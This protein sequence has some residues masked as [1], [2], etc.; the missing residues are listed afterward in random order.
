MGTAHQTSRTVTIRFI[1]PSINQTNRYSLPTVPLSSTVAELRTRLV[2][3]FPDLPFSPA[4]RL[5]FAGRRIHDNVTISDAL[6]VMPVRTYVVA[7]Y[8]WI[9]GLQLTSTALGE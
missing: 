7:T 4:H 8:L 2:E 3:T 6:G 1:S 5:Y 9:L